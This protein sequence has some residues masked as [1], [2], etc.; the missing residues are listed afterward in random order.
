MNLFPDHFLRQGLHENWRSKE[1]MIFQQ[2]MQQQMQSL[3]AHAAANYAMQRFGN[4]PP[5]PVQQEPNL[6]LLLL[7]D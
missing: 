2:Q 6:I 4:Q 5:E 7:E 3:K 1:Q